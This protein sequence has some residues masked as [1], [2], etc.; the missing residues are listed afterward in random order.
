M[1]REAFSI[2]KLES[3]ESVEGLNDD[4]FAQW[5]GKKVFRKYMFLSRVRTFMQI[6]VSANKYK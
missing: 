5:F 4:L 3:V 6:Y 1:I 2:R